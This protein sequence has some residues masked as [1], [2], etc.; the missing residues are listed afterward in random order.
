M[1]DRASLDH[2][3][4]RYVNRGTRDLVSVRMWAY[5]AQSHRGICIGYRT[6]F[7]PFCFAMGVNYEDPTQPLDVLATLEGDATLMADH[8]SLRKGKEPSG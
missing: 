8:V 1:T 6:N 3:A 2:D 5:Y 4:G 7:L